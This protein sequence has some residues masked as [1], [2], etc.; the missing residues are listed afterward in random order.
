[1][2]TTQYLECK[3]QLIYYFILATEHDKYICA[4][5]SVHRG[6]YTD[7]RRVLIDSLR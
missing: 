4:L 2:Y 6:S 1:M 3:T 7:M 5:P